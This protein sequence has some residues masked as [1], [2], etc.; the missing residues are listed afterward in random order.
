MT[1]FEYNPLADRQLEPLTVNMANTRANRPG[2]TAKTTD[3]I[4]LTTITP[5]QRAALIECFGYRSL[6][7]I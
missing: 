2:L 6:P 4:T 7:Y 5:I 1:Y 3:K